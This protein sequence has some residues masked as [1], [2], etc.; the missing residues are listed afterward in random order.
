MSLKFIIALTEHR[1]LGYILAPYL[2]KE[3]ESGPFYTIV[4]LV[5]QHDLNQSEYSF[6]NSEKEL[7]KLSENYSDETLA[8]KYSKE[9]NLQDFYKKTS[10]ETFSNLIIPRI[11]KNILKSIRLIRECGIPLYL[12][13][14]K[15]SNLYDEDLIEISPEPTKAIFNFE[16]T[17]TEIRYFLSIMH[18]DK[19]IRLTNKKAIILTNSPCS[20]V[21]NNRLYYFDDVTGKNLTPF[22]EKQYISVPL[23]ME[24][25]YFKTFILN[26][27]IHNKVNAIGFKISESYPVPEVILSIENTITNQPALVLQFRY[28]SK[29]FLANDPDTHS[30]Y[31]EKQEG[32]YVFYKFNRDPKFEKEIISQLEALGLKLNQ[33]IFL[34]VHCNSDDPSEKFYSLIQWINEYQHILSEKNIHID[35]NKLESKY[36]TGD[37]HLDFKFYNNDDWF[38][39]YAVVSFGSFQIPFIRFKKNILNG[40]REFELP[41]GEIAI[42]PLEWFSKYR[43]IFPFAGSE[44]NNIR[45]KNHH[46]QLVKDAFIEKDKQYIDDFEKLTSIEKVPLIPVPE[47]LKAQLRS[48]QTEGFS[49]MEHLRINKFGGCL[50]DDMGLGKTLQTLTL[51]LKQKKEHHDPMSFYLR[52]EGQ[53]S[54]F[55]AQAPS[56]PIQPASLI[57]VPTSLIHNWENE[58]KKFTP[59]LKCFRYVGSKRKKNIKLGLI[60]QHYDIILTTYG[61]LRNDFQTLSQYLFYYLILDESQYI[62]NPASKTYKAVLQIK[63]QH[64]LVIT[65]TPIENSLLD[66]WA[67]LNFLNPGL[68]GSMKYFQ[69]EYIQPVEKRNDEEQQA[70]LKKLIQPFILRRTKDEVARDLPPLTEQVLFCEMSP[71]QKEIYE[72]EKSAVRN[73][74][75]NSVDQNG[76]EQSTIMVLQGLTRLRQLA[77]HPVLLR[78]DYTADSGKFNE[79]LRSISNLMA[80]NHKVLIFSTFVSHLNLLAKSFIKK[81]WKYTI[82]TGQTTDREKVIN[83]FQEDENTRIF[84]I[85]LKAGGV[86]LNLTSADYVFII[87][88]WWNPAAENQAIN[89]AHRIGQ[90]KKVFVYRFIAKHT[91]EQKIQ[92]LKERKSKLAELFINSNNPL[93]TITREEIIELFT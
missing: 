59:K 81:G 47:G 26:S 39:I 34:P 62:K 35:Q 21:L 61:T 16:R 37:R 8:A 63:S 70:K 24:E 69:Q 38:D 46:F 74:I 60:I 2:I 40:I 93:K 75:M 72:E 86:G 77:N 73:Q 56:K 66:L 71:E 54:L 7:I 28:G 5:R 23:S 92:H 78:D 11:E 41:N 43:D 29:E 52:E 6:S 83:E 33:S 51:L 32:E 55:G 1:N 64:K 27:I 87:D 89:R 22:F 25:K 20:L 88:P 13:A 44:G 15:Y 49:W 9:K 85:S 65:G 67:Q 3:S 79:I 19:V 80:E 18:N 68:L 14:A 76:I 84:L 17:Q 10:P 48:Y 90:D 57:V 91:I 82:L 4:K 31:L 58:I 36:Y 45:F 30:V 53:L 50:A 42:L 12:K